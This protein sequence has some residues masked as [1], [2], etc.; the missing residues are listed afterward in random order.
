V[1]AQVEIVDAQLHLTLD[2]DERRLLA[3][4]DEDGIHAAVLDE[5]WFRTGTGLFMPCAVLP[6]GGFRPLSTYVQGAV[7]RRPGRFSFLQRIEVRDPERAAVVRVL[8]DAPG[9][10]AVRLMLFT[11]DDRRLVADGD[12]D[13]VLAEAQARSLALCVFGVTLSILRS[14]TAQF[15]ELRVVLDHCG[16]ARDTDEWADVLRAAALPQVHL[17]WCHPHR[18]FGHDGVGSRRMRRGLLQAVEAF[19]A[20]RVLWASDITMEDSGASRAE[21]LGVV[22]DNEELSDQQKEWI[23]GRAA[24]RVLARPPNTT[25]R[26]R[27]TEVER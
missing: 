12:Y 17:K 18:V 1:S 27:P 16:G 14:V 2:H 24:R 22:R 19:G 11:D 9:C 15:P 13:D 21:L 20:E 23:L 3:D 7:L 10:R 5:F 6:D 8:A 4:M 25:A 26:P